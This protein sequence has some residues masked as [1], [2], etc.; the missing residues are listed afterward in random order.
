[1]PMTFYIN[2]GGTYHCIS[3]LSNSTVTNVLFSEAAK[4]ISLDISGP[5][6]TYGACNVTIP[7]TLLWGA[8][9]LY[10]DGSV[11]T[12]DVNYTRFYNGTHNT[13]LLNY[14]HSAHIIEIIATEVIPEF[15]AWLILPLFTVA[16][17]ILAKIYKTRNKQL[18]TV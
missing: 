11:L 6:G 13:F 4:K 2:A 18:K 12:E 8:F 3:T 9:S 5:A 17:L 15:T 10:L 16:T 7:E 1:M 14:A